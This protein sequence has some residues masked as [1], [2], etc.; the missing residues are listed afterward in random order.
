MAMSRKTRCQHYDGARVE[1][2]D[3]HVRSSL[4]QFGQ[5][6]YE[7]GGYCGPRLQKDVELVLLY[8]GACGVTVDGKQRPLRPG[9]VYLFLPRHREEFRFSDQCKTH[10]SWCSLTPALVGNDLR[11]RLQHAASEAPPS[12]LFLHLMET[13]F[14]IGP[15]QGQAAE[16]VVN[17]LALGLL[18][19]Y[20]AMSLSGGESSA[21]DPCVV[22]AQRYMEEHY[23]RPD[24]LAAAH[25]AA[26]CCRNALI[27]RFVRATTLTPSRYLWRL[28]TEKGIALLGGTGLTVAEIADRCGFK[29]PFHFSRLVR[30][31]HG[32]SPR[33]TRTRAWQ[34]R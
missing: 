21:S 29:T 18:H 4:A 19:E 15:V 1:W 6:V 33:E 34:I 13:A 27:T 24:C 14:L 12:P 23:S 3:R 28:R 20:L 16:Q 25:K 9:V 26:G 11:R 30:Q 22:K 17:H 2:A 32:C 31:F 8:H 10:H 5:V 7:P